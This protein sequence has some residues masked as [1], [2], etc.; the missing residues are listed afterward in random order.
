MS[1][2]EAIKEY[3]EKCNTITQYEAFNWFGI[4]RLSAIIW[5]LINDDLVEVS[6]Q[7]IKV[8]SRYGATQCKQYYL[9]KYEHIFKVEVENES[10]S[11]CKDNWQHQCEIGL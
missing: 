3:L 1:Q 11:E 4:S 5:S 8:K 7:Y 2:K 9:K 6:S 10:V